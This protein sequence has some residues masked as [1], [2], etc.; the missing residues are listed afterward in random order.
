MNFERI[1]AVTCQTTMNN[2]PKSMT[3]EDRKSLLDHTEKCLLHLLRNPPT[4]PVSRLWE[5]DVKAQASALGYHFADRPVI[6]RRTRSDIDA[7]IVYGGDMVD[8]F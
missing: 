5:R 3:P 1:C 4:S 8:V 2:N 7:G 6:G